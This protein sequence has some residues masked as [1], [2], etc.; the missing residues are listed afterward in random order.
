MAVIHYDLRKIPTAPGG[1]DAG[2]YPAV[3]C[4]GTLKEEELY[5]SI[6]RMSALSAG[7]VKSALSA[8]SHI[9]ATSLGSGRRVEIPELGYFSLAL[10]SDS[11]ILNPHDKQVAS[12]LQ[13]GGIQFHPKKSLL[14]RVGVPSFHRAGS[15][16][17]SV[18]IRTAEETVA[19]LRN[20]FSKAGNE[21]LTSYDFRQLTGY[22]KS[23]AARQL[24][25]LVAEGTLE[26][27]GR[28]NA[29]YYRLAASAGDG[30]A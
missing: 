26:K 6:E 11:R 30:Q 13:V 23:T 3:S 28:R 8:L 14:K 29:P 10:K 24:A 16:R 1:E 18:A 5:V 12:H 7:D 15:S 19:L 4:S 25:L 2:Y 21:V 17:K 20:Y 9:I 22:G 27:F